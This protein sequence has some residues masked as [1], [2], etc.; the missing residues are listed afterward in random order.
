MIKQPA[1]KRQHPR[2]ATV[3][4]AGSDHVPGHPVLVNVSADGACLWLEEAPPVDQYLALSFRCKGENRVLRSRIV[5]SRPSKPMSIRNNLPSSAG[6]LTGI[7]FEEVDTGVRID[8]IPHD[9][10]HAGK[11]TVSFHEHDDFPLSQQV[12]RNDE[13][14]PPALIEFRET[15][16]PAMETAAKDLVPIFAKHFS[17]V[18]LVCTRDRLELTATFRGVSEKTVPHSSRQSAHEINERREPTTATPPHVDLPKYMAAPRTEPAGEWPGREFIVLA[19]VAVVILGAFYF[20]VLRDS[21]DTAQVEPPIAALQ[22]TPPWAQGLALND[23]VRDGWANLKQTFNLPDETVRSMI[24]FMQDNDKYP[25]GHDLHDLSKHPVQVQRALSLLAGA[26][27]ESQTLLEISLLKE[28]LESRLMAGVRFPDELP[29]GR[30][31]S[32]QRELYHNLV[33]L[34]VVDLLYRHQDKPAVK[35]ILAALPNGS[36]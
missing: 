23:E 4:R 25:S 2:I 18:S 14:Q 22:L 33:V 34:G 21:G 7:S 17:D 30:Y 11:A 12:E 27:A 13:N 3:P 26:R 29:G 35:N 10:L 16:I 32:L 8:A 28:E 24:L 9:I 15:S 36:P 6:W 5:W 19:A 1:E 31:S 20:A